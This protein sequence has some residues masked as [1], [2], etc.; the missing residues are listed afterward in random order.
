MAAIGKVEKPHGSSMDIDRSSIIASSRKS[1]VSKCQGSALTGLSYG[2]ARQNQ[3]VTS[4]AFYHDCYSRT[5]AA[6]KSAAMAFSMN[7]YPRLKEAGQLTG[8]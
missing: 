3:S 8:R 6:I 7:G 5:L 1:A 4:R 2:P